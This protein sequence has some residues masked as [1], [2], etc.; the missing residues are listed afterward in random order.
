MEPGK[1]IIA[2]V[3]VV[4]AACFVFLATEQVD[5]RGRFFV[6]GKIE[7]QL[8]RRLREE[9][10]RRMVWIVYVEADANAS[11]YQV[12]Y[13]MDKITGLG[14]KVVWITPKTRKEWEETDSSL[15]SE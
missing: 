15:H 2:G 4:I 7:K 3:V 8:E 13:A 10:G 9:L 12:I 6:N 5:A 1:R 14:G 11:F